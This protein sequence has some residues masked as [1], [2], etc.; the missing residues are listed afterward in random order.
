MINVKISMIFSSS[1][2]AICAFLKLIISIEFS[3]SSFFALDPN[4]A[5]MQ[6]RCVLLMHFFSRCQ[7]PNFETWSHLNFSGGNAWKVQIP[8]APCTTFEIHAF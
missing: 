5:L 2:I 7:K 6:L 3:S 4:Y 1:K 8:A